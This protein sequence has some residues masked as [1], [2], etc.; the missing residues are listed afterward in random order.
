V[1]NFSNRTKHREEIRCPDCS[2]ET[3]R[4]RG[5]VALLDRLDDEPDVAVLVEIAR[6]D[7]EDTQR[8]VAAG[9][10]VAGL[11][12]EGARPERAQLI[13]V[14]VDQDE[15]RH[16]WTLR[17]APPPRSPRFTVQILRCTW[18][19]RAPATHG[20]SVAHS[21]DQRRHPDTFCGL[22]THDP[23]GGYELMWAIANV[24]RDEAVDHLSCVDCQRR[25]ITR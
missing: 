24:D 11:P 3:C 4:C 8:I 25:L 7:R 5:G 15:G 18:K 14:T 17:P 12:D 1:P 23:E 21:Y 13:A 16:V 10:H 6:V 20:R 9:D 22:R 2:A 19:G